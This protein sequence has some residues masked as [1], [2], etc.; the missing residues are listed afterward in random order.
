MRHTTMLRFLALLLFFDSKLSSAQFYGSNFLSAMRGYGGDVCRFISCPVGETC[1]NGV[2]NGGGLLGNYYGGLASPYGGLTGYG[3]GGL[4]GGANKL[5]AETVDCY[6]GQI[7]QAGRCTF[8]SGFGAFPGAV[9]AGGFLP[10]AG[11]GAGL[12]T[13]LAGAGLGTSI[14]GAGLYNGAYNGLG[15]NNLGFALDRPSGVQMCSLVQDCP[16]GQICVNGYCSQSNVVYS[17]SQGLRPLTTCATGAVCPVAHVCLAGS[18]VP[19]YF[20]KSSACLT[21]ATC[22]FGMYCNLGRCTPTAFYGKKK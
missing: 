1:V 5:C 2:C 11:L 4:L 21:S 15:Y 19:N 14:A 17:G 7:C 12:G 6:S 9:G 22:P 20:S 18:C 8:T 3:A 13:P 16:N 10:G